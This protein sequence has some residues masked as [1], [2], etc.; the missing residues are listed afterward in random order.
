VPKSRRTANFI[1]H[2][3]KAKKINEELKS[4]NVRKNLRQET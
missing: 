4:T 1:Y 3:D 2:T